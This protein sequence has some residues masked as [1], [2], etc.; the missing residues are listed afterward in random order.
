MS[1]KDG[2]TPAE[3]ALLFMTCADHA[4]A[5][6]PACD[7]RYKRTE[8]GAD[9]IG[10]LAPRCPACGIDLTASIR[11]HLLSCSA[12]VAL[13]AQELRAQAVDLQHEAQRQMKRSEQARTRAD[14]LAR[15]N[16]VRRQRDEG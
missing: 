12:A 7:R 15:E 11:E 4:V 1:V 5:H 2:L 9:L 16:E 13:E 14:Q 10:S 8:A 6:C 3:R